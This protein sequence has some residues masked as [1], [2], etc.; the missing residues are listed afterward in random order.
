MNLFF[1]FFQETKFHESNKTNEESNA[2]KPTSFPSKTQTAEGEK[3]ETTPGKEM[4][5]EETINDGF[6]WVRSSQEKQKKGEDV[7]QEGLQSKS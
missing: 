2:E 1:S 7:E 3:T 5:L 4:D 6:L